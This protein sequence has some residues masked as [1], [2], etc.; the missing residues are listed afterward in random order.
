MESVVSVDLAAK[1][2]KVANVIVARGL[3]A[4]AIFLL[5][6]YKPLHRLGHN[7]ALISM[8]LIYPLVG[9]DL[10]NSTLQLL[11]DNQAVEYLILEIE[12]VLN[13]KQVEGCI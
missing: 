13:D 3:G 10:Y 1:I 2:S 11:E 9:K 6:S 8:P 7:S 4:P 5:E 12:R